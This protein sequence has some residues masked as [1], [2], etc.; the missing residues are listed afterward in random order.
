MQNTNTTGTPTELMHAAL[1][2]QNNRTIVFTPHFSNDGAITDFI[3]S[4][5]SRGT[6]DFFGEDP[7][8]K[9]VS[10][11]LPDAPHQI[12]ILTQT[13]TSGV[14]KNWSKSYD[15]G[16]D[17]PQWF[18]VTDTKSGNYVVRT[19]EN[20]TNR[21]ITE[22]EN[23]RKHVAVAEEK[24]VALFNAIDQGFCIIEMVFNDDN[25]P[26]DYIFLQYNPAFE[27]QT[28][29]INAQGKKMR[30]LYPAH[31]QHWFDL[32]GEIALTGVSKH[33]EQ[34]AALIDGWYEVSAFPLT[35]ERSNFVGIIF[36]DI[37]ERKKAEDA[38]NAFNALL[39][40][41]V[42][43]RTA[44]LNTAN[45]QLEQKIGELDKSNK[46]L[47][48][49]TY[50][51][52]HDLQEP[53]RK[54]Q[55]FLTLIKQRPDNPEM[56]DEYMKKI[57]SSTERM[58]KLI[59]DVLTFSRVAAERR[60]DKTDLNAVL[61]NVLIDYE[62]AITEKEARVYS[63]TLPV[64]NAVSLQMH[65]LF[66]NLVSNSLKYATEKPIITVT[67][68]TVIHHGITMAQITFADNGI[69]FDQQYADQ[70]FSL[71]KRLHG[72]SEYQGSGI[73]LSTCKKIVEQHGGSISAQSTYGNG[74]VF[75]ILLP[76]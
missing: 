8:G 33:F 12:K 24:Y 41:E 19:W 53:L 56:V 47:E 57:F 69:G 13:Y 76:V 9:K 16:Q 58:S 3:F 27:K 60:P 26:V 2:A 46:E 74:A 21:R 50:I 62:V 30:D 39:E 34:E 31:E 66:S 7:S 70:I 55:T 28:G 59:T 72:R 71:F 61:A 63:E 25:I 52:S 22:E 42:K 37:S 49:F 32:Y 75:T 48:S 44:S 68:K 54:I 1:N 73:G 10:E 67:S 51:A 38:L 45:R 64:I 15:I 40:K 20:S 65:Q 4:L 17:T 5:V 36:N 23:K 11:V 43:E 14:A 29:L 6:L 18:D 35:K